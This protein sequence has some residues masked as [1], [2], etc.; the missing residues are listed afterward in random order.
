M[1]PSCRIQWQGHTNDVDDITEE[2]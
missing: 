1:T 2:S